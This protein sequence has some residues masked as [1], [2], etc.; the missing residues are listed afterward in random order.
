MA[1]T[2]GEAGR[3][4]QRGG[5]EGGGEGGQGARVPGAGYLLRAGR[6]RN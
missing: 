4:H 5:R 6:E 2:H 1:Q 3:R